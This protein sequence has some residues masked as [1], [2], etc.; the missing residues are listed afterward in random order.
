M[1]KS[2]LKTDEIELIVECLEARAKSG[3]I[4]DETQDR[5]LELLEKLDKSED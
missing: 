4:S 3:F 5:I 1:K 2:E